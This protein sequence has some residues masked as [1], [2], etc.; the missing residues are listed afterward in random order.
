MAVSK[1]QIRDAE[2]AFENWIAGRSIKG[3]DEEENAKFIDAAVRG[4]LKWMIDEDRI[5]PLAPGDAGY[6]YDTAFNT[7]QE[8]EHFTAGY[9]NEPGRGTTGKALG[10]MF[11]PIAQHQIT[12]PV[13]RQM[14]DP[15]ADVA[16]DALS[17]SRYLLP[18]IA[19]YAKRT[20]LGAATMAGG[21]GLAAGLL[22]KGIS[23]ARGDAPYGETPENIMLTATAAAAGGAANK[24][25]AEDQVRRRQLTAKIEQN[26]GIKRNT[27][28]WD[29][30]LLSRVEE[31][32]KAKSLALP[33]YTYG[34][35]RKAPLTDFDAA[36]GAAEMPVKFKRPPTVFK[37]EKSPIPLKRD[38]SSVIT[39]EIA[40]R[41]VDELGLDRGDVNI[42]DV[43]SW[44]Q[45]AWLRPLSDKGRMFYPTKQTQMDVSKKRWTALK[46]NE[47][48][49]F[50][51][52][53]LVSGA[54]FEDPEVNKQWEKAKQDYHERYNKIK[55]RANT[56]LVSKSDYSKMGQIRVPIAG[57]IRPAL[58]VS[59]TALAPIATE[60]LGKY[61]LNKLPERGTND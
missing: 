23:E 1:R 26:L 59:A 27:P 22:N 43:K 28:G 48:S 14:R 40:T 5:I 51:A 24:A 57:N 50:A 30:G 10:S 39:D 60:V 49:Q 53:M 44:L 34:D 16:Q 25:L 18:I 61:I 46:A 19:Q 21:Y 4:S 15:A 29:K 13:R 47:P 52:D 7:P 31:P 38:K 32:L 45:E 58:R 37:G 12:D 35:W 2:T 20:P 42:D 54:F 56:P 17:T 55:G 6:N 33:E 9:G 3:F 41:F 11:A 36:T 8:A